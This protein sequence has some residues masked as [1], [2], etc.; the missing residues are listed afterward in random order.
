MHA[1]LHD[2][3][4]VHD[5]GEPDDE[6]ARRFSQVARALPLHAVA[7]A[8]GRVRPEP[9]GE[10]LAR[11]LGRILAAVTH[12]DPATWERLKLCAAEDC[13]RAFVD[14]SRN[15]SRRWCDMGACGNRQKTRAYRR[16]ARS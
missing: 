7:D 6:A 3:A 4:G 5:D 9:A 13:R 1:A 16:R 11:A 15:R 14:A 12:A 2:L 10:G 8:E